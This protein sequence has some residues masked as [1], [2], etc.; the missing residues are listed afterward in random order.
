MSAT[1]ERGDAA[2]LGAHV[3]RSRTPFTRHRRMAGR[4]G[5][6]PRKLLIVNRL[7]RSRITVPCRRGP[8]PPVV[9]D[10]NAPDGDQQ[11]GQKNEDGQGRRR[12]AHGLPELGLIDDLEH[13]AL[14][15]SDFRPILILADEAHERVRHVPGR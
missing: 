4:R 7:D 1:G 5:G 11:D 12:R 6:D 13:N 8:H 3:P 9:E 15:L 2:A 10:K 14:A